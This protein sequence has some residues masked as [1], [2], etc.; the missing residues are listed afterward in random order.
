[1]GMYGSVERQVI[2]K[3]K[4]DMQPIERTT[5][6]AKFP[7]FS[8][9]WI[10]PPLHIEMTLLIRNAFPRIRMRCPSACSGKKPTRVSPRLWSLK[11]LRTAVAIS[12]IT[13][14]S[15]DH[16]R[17]SLHRFVSHKMWHQCNTAL[18]H[19]NAAPWRGRLAPI[20]RQGQACPDLTQFCPAPIYLVL[21]DGSKEELLISHLR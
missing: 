7:L 13:I 9:I 20:G 2:G 12:S 11:P 10:I 14:E 1:M 3:F 4:V 15:L 17:S 16:H 8:R 5:G 18:H 19:L 6:G 21:A